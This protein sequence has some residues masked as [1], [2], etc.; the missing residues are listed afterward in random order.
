M[1]VE[2]SW[3]TINKD[4]TSTETVF[5]HVVHCTVHCLKFESEHPLEGTKGFGICSYQI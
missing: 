3:E 5:N 1:D 4:A 2:R